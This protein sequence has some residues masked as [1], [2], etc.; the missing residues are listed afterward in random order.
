MT[1]IQEQIQELLTNNPGMSLNQLH[2]AIG[3]SKDIGGIAYSI[4]QMRNRRI[5]TTEYNSD[6][7]ENEYCTN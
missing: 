7:R 6:T 5:V 4:M 1:K 3:H 2:M